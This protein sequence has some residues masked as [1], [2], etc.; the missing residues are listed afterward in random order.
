MSLPEQL[1]PTTRFF[2]GS[3]YLIAWDGS[4]FIIADPKAANAGEL[5]AKAGG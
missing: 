2:N 1:I 5:L 4:K 3:A